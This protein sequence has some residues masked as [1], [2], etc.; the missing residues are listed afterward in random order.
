MRR[1]R[2]P[3]QEGPDKWLIRRLRDSGGWTG[4]RGCGS[5]GQEAGN[6]PGRQQGKM[7]PPAGEAPSLGRKEKCGSRDINSGTG[8]RPGV[9]V[10]DSA[11]SISPKGD[12]LQG[13][14]WAFRG[15]GKTPRIWNSIAG[16]E[17]TSQDHLTGG[18]GGE[19]EPHMTP[20]QRPW[21]WADGR[22]GVPGG[23]LGDREH[24]GPRAV[25]R[26]GWRWV[27]AGGTG[28]GTGNGPSH[29]GPRPGQQS[30][31]KR[32]LPNAPPPKK[33]RGRG[34]GTRL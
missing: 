27:R 15:S 30:A 8:R 19:G 26:A 21:A 17:R 3:S 14:G 31:C 1:L 2:P 25:V 22:W 16:A 13:G 18:P 9:P 32:A 4:G 12:L 11:L 10:S 20:L 5:W 28:W 6:I 33:S 23:S 7:E 24:K 29:M 34:E